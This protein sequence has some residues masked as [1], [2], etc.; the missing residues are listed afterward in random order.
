MRKAFNSTCEESE[1]LE[2]TVGQ[3]AEIQK[4]RVFIG[5]EDNACHSE[6]K[7]MERVF[8]ARNTKALPL[9]SKENT[10][11][12]FPELQNHQLIVRWIN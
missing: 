7:T 4:S 9:L 12:N 8:D 3:P 5:P 1:A 11:T 10:V 2:G 6:E